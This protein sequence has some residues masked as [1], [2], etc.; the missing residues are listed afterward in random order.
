MAISLNPYVSFTDNAREAMTFYQTVFG[1]ELT[2]STFGE[3]H[4]SEDPN[5]VDL[6]MHSVLTTGTGFTLMASDTSNRMARDEGT[7]ISISVSGDAEDEQ[8]LRTAWAAM[9]DGA[10]ITMP[11]ETAMWGDTFGMLTD[12]F[13][14]HWMFSIGSAAS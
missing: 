3:M 7:E 8:S 14:L 9:S 10:E 12:R 4:A 11:L 5:V 2:L 6:I 13:G 1:G